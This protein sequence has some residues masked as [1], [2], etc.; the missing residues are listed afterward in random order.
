MRPVSTCQYEK[1]LL[2]SGL[3]L[4]VTGEGTDNGILLAAEAVDGTLR[5]ALG[6]SS[7]VLGLALSVFVT[8]R[9]LPRL[10]TGQV[11]DCLDDGALCRVVLT[12]GLAKNRVVRARP[13]A[14]N[15][16]VSLLGLVVVGGG[17]HDSKVGGG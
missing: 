13:S 16:A 15:D 4:T 17:G 5:V 2:T 8:T 6:L 9:C 11:A 12:G 14:V 3:L 10:S 1:R 7:V